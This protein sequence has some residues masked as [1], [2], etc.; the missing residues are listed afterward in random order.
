MRREIT[1]RGSLTV[2]QHL[3]CISRRRDC[4]TAHRSVPREVKGFARARLTATRLYTIINDPRTGINILHSARG[5][6][7]ALCWTVE[8]AGPR[9][10]LIHK[11][12][13]KDAQCEGYPPRVPVVPVF[14]RC[15]G[16]GRSRHLTRPDGKACEQIITAARTT[17]ADGVYLRPAEDKNTGQTKTSAWTGIIAN[18]NY[19]VRHR[20]RTIYLDSFLSVF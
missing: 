10:N 7:A 19:F 17:N 3:V 6:H 18:T 20:N 15:N 4:H 9:E 12:R 5:R 13:K 11:P 8:R 14:V 16:T 1:A 2:Q